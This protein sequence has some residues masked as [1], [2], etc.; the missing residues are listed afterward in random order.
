ME[1]RV[2]CRFWQTLCE[3]AELDEYCK[4]LDSW[5]EQNMHS[6]QIKHGVGVY[7]KELY[8]RFAPRAVVVDLDPATAD[9]IATSHRSG[10]RS[11]EK[12]F[13]NASCIVGQKG[14]GFGF[15]KGHYTAGAEI[16][17]QCTDAVR[18]EVERCALHFTS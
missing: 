5:S 8:G 11:H 16:I 10:C 4:P 7:F 18:S 17:G 13:N 2:G 6:K 9:Y 15:A 3:E 12:I 1:Y 14:T